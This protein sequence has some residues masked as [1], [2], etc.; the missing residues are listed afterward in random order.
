MAHK[1][2]CGN[3]KKKFI[4]GIIAVVIVAVGGY[5]YVNSNKSNDKSENKVASSKKSKP[6]K[7]EKK[8]SDNST[9]NTAQSANENS[10]SNT[11]TNN[12]SSSAK[13]NPNPQDATK[14]V[15]E[16]SQEEIYM[17][18]WVIKK[19]LAYAPASTYSKE[20]I[21]KLIGKKL[22]FSADSATCFGDSI[23][24][25]D[26][27]VK[28]P[29]YQ[30][31]SVLKSDF[32]QNNKVTLDKLGLSGSTVTQVQVQDASGNGCVFYIKDSKT[33][34]LSGGGVYFEIDKQ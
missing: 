7:A 8:V 33:M 27:T 32:E 25:M 34:I 3:M 16:K 28:T 22:V 19:D 15:R 24:D 12:N 5:I 4:A 18:T 2:E 9:A 14:A 21:N 30:K 10:S 17:G 6:Q 13:T 23:S 26:K 11:S 20:D 31:T 29:M 1:K